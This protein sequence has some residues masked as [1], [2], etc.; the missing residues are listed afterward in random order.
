MP[1]QERIARALCRLMDDEWALGE[2][3]YMSRAAEIMADIGY[4]EMFEALRAV[5]E[6]SKSGADTVSFLVELH[7]VAKK[8]SA[9]AAKAEGRSN[10]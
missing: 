2:K 5:D 10:G 6:V 9:A 1:P 4:L 3:L 8:C 7:H